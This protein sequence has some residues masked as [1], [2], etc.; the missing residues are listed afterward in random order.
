MPLSR[1]LDVMFDSL[2]GQGHGSQ[3]GQVRDTV[4]DRVRDVRGDFFGGRRV[5]NGQQDRLEDL[6]RKKTV[7]HAS[8]GKWEKVRARSNSFNLSDESVQVKLTLVKSP[9]SGHQL[10]PLPRRTTSSCG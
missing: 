2:R 8:K 10:T 1:F 6:E 9:P 5:L 4:L 3:V 7:Y